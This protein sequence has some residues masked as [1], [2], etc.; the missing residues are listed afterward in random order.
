M[1]RK[2]NVRA[3]E[4]LDKWK[5]CDSTV[6]KSLVYAQNKMRAENEGFPSI[7]EVGKSMGLTQHEVAAVLGWTTGDFR[8]INPIARGQEEVEFE[9][10]PKGQRTMCKLSRA[11]VMPYVQVLHG[12]VQKLP[13][14]TSTQPLY[15]GHRREVSLP[16]GSVVLLPGFTSTSY[17]MDGALAFAKQANQGRSAKRTLLVIQESFSGRLVAKLSARKYEAEVLFPI[18]TCFKVVEALPS[19]ATEAAAKAA[20]E[21]R[22]SMSEAEIRVVC[23]HEIEKPEDA[24]VVPL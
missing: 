23:L 21:L 12:A 2:V 19:P 1:K 17:D 16:V 24:T 20:E 8:L 9:D 4:L 15:R 6:G 3:F 7:M 11:D 10:F 18:D 13:A 5:N 22:Q 14:L